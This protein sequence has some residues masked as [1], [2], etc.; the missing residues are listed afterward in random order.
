MLDYLKNF[1]LTA[2]QQAKL[3][4]KLELVRNRQNVYGVI[5]NRFAQLNIP[6]TPKISNSADNNV[7]HQK[8]DFDD[9]DFDED[10]DDCVDEEKR[11][12]QEIVQILEPK[13]WEAYL[14]ELNLEQSSLTLQHAVEV[15]VPFE[16]EAVSWLYQNKDCT[17]FMEKIWRPA[18]IESAKRCPFIKEDLLVFVNGLADQWNHLAQRVV[19]G[20][21][22]FE[23]MREIIDLQPDANCLSNNH[24]TSQPIDGVLTSYNSFRNIEEFRCII[25]P[26]IAGL[27]LFSINEK[28][29]IDALYNYIES[30]L[31]KNWETMTLAHVVET[32]IIR[33]INNELNIDIENP[34]ALKAM[35]FIS[36]LVTEENNSPLI[37]WLRKKTERDMEAIGK[38]LQGTLIEAYGIY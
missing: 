21:V 33:I 28:E 16:W 37:E 14:N 3:R 7:E 17:L 26:F 18:V 23:E 2:D 8:D 38:I 32:G 6:C 13:D 34:R 15:T 22:S 35:K 19:N 11:V 5:Y 1:G 36:S 30:N 12:Y 24:L 25:S 10:E 20:S 29:P 31:L 9:E 27:R 4:Q